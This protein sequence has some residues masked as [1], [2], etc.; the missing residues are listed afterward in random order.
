MTKKKEI[1]WKKWLSYEWVSQ[2]ELK[3]DKKGKKCYIVNYLINIAVAMKF[4]H[5][6]L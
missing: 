5:M 2:L 3:Q 1:N 6:N 4:M